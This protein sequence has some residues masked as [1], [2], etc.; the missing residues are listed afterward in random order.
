MKKIMLFV[1]AGVLLFA[2]AGSV[3][4][5][6]TKTPKQNIVGLVGQQV[7]VEGTADDQLSLH[8]FSLK[9]THLQS[10]YG[11]YVIAPASFVP[12]GPFGESTITVVGDVRLFDLQK[13]NE[14]SEQPIPEGAAT[15]L[16]GKPIII[17]TSVTV[18]GEE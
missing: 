7:T 9:G 2:L 1:F 16:S 8:F 14:G 15:A 3:Y 4:V 10:D 13:Y 17:A 18:E 5:F 11:V 6:R 12:Q